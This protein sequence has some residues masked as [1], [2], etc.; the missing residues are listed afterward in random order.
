MLPPTRALPSGNTSPHGSRRPSG[1]RRY[2]RRTRYRREVCRRSAPASVIGE[3]P[4]RV[5]RAP[6]M[7]TTTS[8]SRCN[9]TDRRLYL[10]RS[11]ETES[12]T[13]VFD[14]DGPL[15]RQRFQSSF[16]E[17]PPE[18]ARLQQSQLPQ[19]SRVSVSPVELAKAQIKRDLLSLLKLGRRQTSVDFRIVVLAHLARGMVLVH[20][21][22]IRVEADRCHDPIVTLAP[23]GPSLA[24]AAAESRPIRWKGEGT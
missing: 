19:K 6:S 15:R 20:H 11:V 23:P 10:T 14:H 4:P 3:T 21:V 1:C 7:T 5:A 12:W 16:F 18:S 2:R 9:E 13:R 24:A 17:A 8:Y 22:D